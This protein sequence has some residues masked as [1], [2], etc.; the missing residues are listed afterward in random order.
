MKIKCLKYI[1]LSVYK[2]KNKV[3]NKIASDEEKIRIIQALQM[4]K[5]DVTKYLKE[6][7]NITIHNLRKAQYEEILRAENISK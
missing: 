6:K 3:D 4:K 2:I 7:Y 1:K 5:I